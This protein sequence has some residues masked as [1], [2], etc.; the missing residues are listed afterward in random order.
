MFL[1]YT[2]LCFLRGH[3]QKC[4]ELIS[5]STLSNNLWFCSGN[6]RIPRIKLGQRGSALP[7]VLSPVPSYFTFLLIWMKVIHTFI[8]GKAASWIHEQLGF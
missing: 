1:F 6:S 8:Q 3:K 4:T 2:F 7:S 5:G